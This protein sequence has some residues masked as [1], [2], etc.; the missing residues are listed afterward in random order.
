MDDV[1]T[2]KGGD[3]G[4]VDYDFGSLLFTNWF[5]A[6]VM[7]RMHAQRTSMPLT[8]DQLGVRAATETAVMIGALIG[9]YLACYTFFLPFVRGI[10]EGV[11]EYR[12]F[13][14][15]REAKW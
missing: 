10:I 2:D 11:A 9:C 8:P 4:E 1:Q 6:G 3:S 13:R 15:L 5:I 7:E 14:G 12:P